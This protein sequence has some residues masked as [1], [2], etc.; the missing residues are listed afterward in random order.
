[1]EREEVGKG[2]RSQS[3]TAG[4]STSSAEKRAAVVQ[5]CVWRWSQ[6]YQ[7]REESGIERRGLA[8]PRSCP[9]RRDSREGLVRTRRGVSW[10]DLRQLWGTRLLDTGVRECEG[11]SRGSCGFQE[12]LRPS[13]HARGV[14]WARAMEL[15][16]AGT[17]REATEERVLRPGADPSLSRDGG[18]GGGRARARGP[19]AE[20]GLRLWDMG[21][22]ESGGRER[23]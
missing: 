10:P 12:D 14:R 4:S 1:M 13:R 15:V 8:V 16:E 20:E 21:M 23:R 18:L 7:I 9:N 17:W 19:H 11:R 3:G 6:K 2:L 5:G 22:Q